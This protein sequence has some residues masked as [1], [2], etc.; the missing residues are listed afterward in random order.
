VLHRYDW[1]E[2]S[3]ILEIFTL[4]RGRLTVVAKGAKRPYSQL[5]SVLLPFQ[6]IFVATT[7][8][9]PAERADAS[10]SDIQTLRSAEWAGGAAMFSGAALF[11]GFYLNELLM[12]LLGRQDPQPLLFDA[13]M[14]VLRVLHEAGDAGPQAEAGLRA[15]ELRLL[16]ET[17]VLPDLSLCTLTQVPVRAEGGYRLTADMGVTE[18]PRKAG[19]DTLT[20]GLLVNLQAALVHGSFPALQQACGRELN[21]LKVAL[22][23][24]LHYHL[25]SAP[26]RTRQLMLDMQAMERR[27]T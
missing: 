1:S 20:G 25:G 11:S 16:S 9:A 8:G 15:F 2:S 3:L 22:R 7:R 21:A 4:E 23:G 17:G 6:R 12:K 19:E 13:Y 18:A 5:R 14:Q 27:G 26:L 10:T 24:L